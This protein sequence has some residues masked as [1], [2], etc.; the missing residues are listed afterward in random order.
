[1]LC[2]TDSEF[3]CVGSVKPGLFNR[4]KLGSK[5]GT[6]PTAHSLRGSILFHVCRAAEINTLC[7]PSALEGKRNEE[8]EVPPV[9]MNKEVQMHLCEK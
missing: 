4:A 1:M 6:G 7:F 5:A 3:D 9:E 2:S 8:G